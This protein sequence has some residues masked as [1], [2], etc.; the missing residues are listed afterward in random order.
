MP[1]PCANA[2]ANDPCANACANVC[3]NACASEICALS[4][5]LRKWF[6][7]RLGNKMKNFHLRKH[8]RKH[9]RR[10]HLRKHLRRTPNI[11]G[12]AEVPPNPPE[13]PYFFRTDPL[14]FASLSGGSKSIQR[15]VLFGF[16]LSCFPWVSVSFYFATFATAR[17][18]KKAHLRSAFAQAIVKGPCPVLTLPTSQNPS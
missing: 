16:S 8:L 9:L 2:C 3:A 10:G 12:G 15:C 18:A 6:L 7:W 13:D 4:Q 1:C 14:R 5:T 11:F 17:K